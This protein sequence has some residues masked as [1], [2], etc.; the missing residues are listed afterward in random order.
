MG[1]ENLMVNRLNEILA[2]IENTRQETFRDTE[3]RAERSS[4][5]PNKE[6][7]ET[8]LVFTGQIL[9]HVNGKQ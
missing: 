8:A 1:E 4:R 9:M 6:E 7:I 3:A 5:I 2:S